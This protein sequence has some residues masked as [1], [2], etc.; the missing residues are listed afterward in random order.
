[1]TNKNRAT[2]IPEEEAVACIAAAAAASSTTTTTRAAVSGRKRATATRTSQPQREEAWRAFS[3]FLG[4]RVRPSSSSSYVG[5]S[6]AGAPRDSCCRGVRSGAEEGRF[7]C[8]S[9]PPVSHSSCLFDAAIECHR[10]QQQSCS[11]LRMDHDDVDDGR[12]G[13]L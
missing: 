12:F 2:G 4:A 3:V 9:P 13:S 7:F 1:M 5:G 8:C 6:A 10:D 11:S